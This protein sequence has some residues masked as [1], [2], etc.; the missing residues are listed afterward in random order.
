LLLA[1]SIGFAI[2]SF[3]ITYVEWQQAAE[4][5]VGLM[6]LADEAAA[7]ECLVGLARHANEA[8]HGVSVSRYWK[9]DAIEYQRVPQLS[10]V[11]L[12]PYLSPQRIETRVTRQR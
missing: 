7:K 9:A 6:H 11:D 3:I 10:G 2:S 1:G 4:A 8:G 5:Y 12:D